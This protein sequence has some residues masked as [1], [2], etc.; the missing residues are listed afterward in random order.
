MPHFCRVHLCDQRDLHATAQAVHERAQL[1]TTG[2]HS[3]LCGHILSAGDLQAVH[4]RRVQRAHTTNPQAHTKRLVRAEQGPDDQTHKRISKNNAALH[5]GHAAGAAH[6]IDQRVIQQYNWKWPRQIAQAQSSRQG[7][8]CAVNFF[9]FY[10][11]H[12][13]LIC[14]FI[15]FLIR[16]KIYIFNLFFFFFYISNI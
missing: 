16:I 1:R 4:E 9:S 13:I 14:N 11:T 3:N 5:C 8:H 12:R 15:N 6:F 10:F 2:G 7:K